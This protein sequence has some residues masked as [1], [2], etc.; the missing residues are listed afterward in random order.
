MAYAYTSGWDG[1]GEDWPPDVYWAPAYS[2]AFRDVRRA[3][4]NPP[5]TAV[6]SRG[7]VA[8]GDTISRGDTK[9]KKLTNFVGKMVKK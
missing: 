3:V 8:P 1:E 2:R 4:L 5:L 6:A 9:R 7:G